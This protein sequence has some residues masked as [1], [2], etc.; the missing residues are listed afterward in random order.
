MQLAVSTHRG[1]CT[2][3]ADVMSAV[4]RP[5]AASTVRLCALTGLT[6]RRW[7]EARFVIFVNRVEAERQRLE[8]GHRPVV[9]VRQSRIT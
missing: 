7:G 4:R 9:F 1:E 6:G 8:H 3:H 5:Q 2:Q